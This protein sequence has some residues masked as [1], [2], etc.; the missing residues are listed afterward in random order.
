MCNN[1]SVIIL[2]AGKGTR[3]KSTLPK[4]LHKILDKPIIL[5]TL[6]LLKSLGINSVVVTG[7]KAELVEQTIAKA[8]YNVK[9]VRQRQALGTAHAVATGLKGITTN[10]KTVLVLYGD[11]SALYKP[12]TIKKFLEFHNEKRN[13]ITLLTTVTDQVSSLGGLKRD[14][15]DNII[16]VYTR[17][18]LLEKGAKFTEIVCGAFCFDLKFLKKYLPQIKKSRETGEY[19][20]PGMVNLA[21]ETGD[22]AQAFK[23]PNKDEWTSVN[24]RE[25]LKKANF[26]RRKLYGN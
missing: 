23:L 2:A 16:G 7:Y 26:L 20:L 19:P 9:F 8:G 3:M 11:D 24:T 17:A 13:K 18:E 5:W 14:I 10:T 6:D 22:F 25:E 1:I 21:A 4:V 12:E 15:N